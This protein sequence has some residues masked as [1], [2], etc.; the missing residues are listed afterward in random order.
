MKI[1][2]ANAIYDAAGVR[3]RELPATPKR[4]HKLIKEK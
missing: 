1:P 4:V 2:I 3:P